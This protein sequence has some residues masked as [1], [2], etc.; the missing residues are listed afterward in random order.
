MHGLGRLFDVGLAVAPV[1]INTSD[2]ATGK[3]ISMSGASGV[4]VLVVTGTGGADDFVI[5]LQQHTAYTGGTSKDLEADTSAGVAGTTET[6][7]YH[8]KAET[9]LDNDESWVKVPVTTGASTTSEV[10]VVGATYGAQQ[11]LVA[12]Y[13]SADQ[14]AD[15][16]GWFS[17]NIAC[18]TSTSQ[19]IA[20]LYLAHDLAS[21]RAAANLPNLLNPGAA[22][23]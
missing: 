5:D 13:V 9:A 8:I 4:T 11:K 2:A 23:A 12:I 1:D 10:T 18:T 19:L 16:Y 3:R 21:Q 14:L 20:V 15:G 17:V 22:N 7:F 6:S